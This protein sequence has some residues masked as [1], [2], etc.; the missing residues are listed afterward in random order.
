MKRIL[1]ILC[2]LTTLCVSAQQQTG[3]RF[4]T[5]S[6]SILITK[7]QQEHKLVFL[8]AYTSWCRPCKWMNENIFT[9]DTVG[10]F[11]NSHFI[12]VQI[13]ME[14]GEGVEI[15]KWYG[16]QCYP[17]YLF[18]DGTGT[19]VHRVSGAYPVQQ[20]IKFGET[21][22]DS[23]KRYS[24]F[25][26]MYASGTMSTQDLIRYVRMR[27]AGCIQNKD[28]IAE[29]EQTFS[30][31]DLI[32]PSAWVLLNTAISSKDSRLF[33]YM[34]THRNTFDAKYTIDSVDRVIE[35]I[36]L[37]A[38]YRS[39]G[40]SNPDT[41][42]YKVMR[43]EVQALD[44]PIADKILQKGDLQLY[45]ATQNWNRYCPSVIAYMDQY[46]NEESYT[47][48]NNYAW[49]VYEHCQNKEHL[50]KALSWVRKSVSI[51][52]EWFNTDTYASV[53]FAL[54][55]L[56]E[57]KTWATISIMLGKDEGMNYATTEKLLEKI[58]SDL[59]K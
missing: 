10:K 48:L 57:A 36:Y 15:A 7:A 26:K 56:K 9:N 14:K 21:A 28:L 51:S 20:F 31:N 59:E 25:E 52:P 42:A 16:V 30:E 38:L 11:Y 6:L 46:G 27:E 37:N 43:N 29:Y 23:N 39:M 22:L 19:V 50:I 13:D 17:L 12:N 5:D 53:Q 44:M 1:I 45:L 24:A 34:C 58:N 35:R 4:E 41:V 49:H 8:D 2:S 54:G 40:Y 18:I 32:S 33:Q 3:I 47:N 55:N